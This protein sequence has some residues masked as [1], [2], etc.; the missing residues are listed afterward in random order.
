M[1]M[2][3]FDA[4]IQNLEA[5]EN[6]AYSMQAEWYLALAYLA[7]EEIDT[8]KAILDKIS[9]DPEHDNFDEASALLKKW[10][11]LKACDK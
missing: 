10:N 6:G 7:K 11:K 1:K 8:S 5:V 9:Q 3:D 2:S 4:A